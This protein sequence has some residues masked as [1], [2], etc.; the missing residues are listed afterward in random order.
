MFIFRSSDYAALEK[1]C[2]AATVSLTDI[3]G[4]GIASQSE[5][6]PMK[7]GRY[8][9]HDYP[10][11]L[12]PADHEVA[13]MAALPIWPSG[14]A[15]KMVRKMMQ[16]RVEHRHSAAHTFQHLDGP[17]WH[18][19]HFNQADIEGGHWTGGSHLHLI[20]WLTHPACELS[21]LVEAFRGA[22]RPPHKGLHVRCVW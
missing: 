1:H 5:E 4:L 17:G 16:G 3:V 6:V 8:F 9:R 13:E 10:D 21:Q 11:H 12:I 7:Y 22:E 14:K 20:N 2:Q 18:F 19:F 15:P